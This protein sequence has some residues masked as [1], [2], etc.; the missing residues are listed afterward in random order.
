MLANQEWCQKF[1][2]AKCM[3]I[4]KEASDHSM[5]MLDIKPRT[6]K[7]GGR[8]YFDKRWVQNQQIQELI[9]RAWDE[10]QQG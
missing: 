5:I 1:E 9:S 10:P 2:T 4:E 3:H 6:R 7:V 8:F